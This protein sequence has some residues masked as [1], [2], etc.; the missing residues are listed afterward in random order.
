MFL[1][2]LKT[3]KTTPITKP[4]I[5]TEA[6]ISSKDIT[7]I[8]LTERA[9]MA[10]LALIKAHGCFRF[11]AHDP[12]SLPGLKKSTSSSSIV[13]RSHKSST[14]FSLIGLLSIVTDDSFH[15]LPKSSS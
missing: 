3:F 11:K 1:F 6:Q 9:V 4:N 2:S 5:A 7:V 15:D 10:I 13:S 12:A 8:V 14:V